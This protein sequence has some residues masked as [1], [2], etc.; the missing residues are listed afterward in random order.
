MVW[1]YFAHSGL[2]RLSIKVAEKNSKDWTESHEICSLMFSFHF[3]FE[4]SLNFEPDA[5]LEFQ[6]R[7][8][9]CTAGLVRVDKFSFGLLG[10]TTV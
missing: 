9:A 1:G 7:T 8:V 3:A 4:L 2:G 6:E 10:K 5:N